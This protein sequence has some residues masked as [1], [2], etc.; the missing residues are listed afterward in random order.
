MKEQELNRAAEQ[1][2]SWLHYYGLGED[3]EKDPLDDAMFYDRMRSIGYTKRVIPLPMRCVCMYVTSD[4]PVLESS[5]EELQSV[6]GPRNHDANVYTAL[7]YVLATKSL[8][9]ERFRNEIKA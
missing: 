9:H 7:E 1:E 3:R 6:S 8:E 5:I 2:S 4:K